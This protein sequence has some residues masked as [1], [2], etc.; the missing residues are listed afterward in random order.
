MEESIEKLQKSPLFKL[1]LSSKEL[2]HSNFWAWFFEQ[3]GN[4]PTEFFSGKIGSDLGKLKNV[5]RETQRK[6]TRK[7]KTVNFDLYLEFEYGSIIIE[8]KI[9]SIPDE[10]QLEEYLEAAIKGNEILFL[11]SPYKPENIDG[12]NHIEYYELL[13]ILNNKIKSNN[14][15]QYHKDLIADY[16][17]FM[18]YLLSLIKG[19]ENM[20][21]FDFHS[22]YNKKNNDYHKFKKIGIHDLFHKYKYNRLAEMLY[23]RVQEK[24]SDNNKLHKHTLFMRGTGVANLEYYFEKDNREQRIELQIQDNNVKLLIGAKNI[25]KH[26]DYLINDNLIQG[27]YSLF[28][29]NIKE[30]TESVIYPKDGGFNKYGDNIIYRRKNINADCKV[31]TIVD[32]FSKFFRDVVDY[33]EKYRKDFNSLFIMVLKDP[34]H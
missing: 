33:T 9:K 29:E 14:I 11:L 1:S 32:Y 25:H 27:L 17:H 12:Y 18:S 31:E 5:D 26:K 19:W 7:N 3:E 34:E 28:Q 30:I 10:T 24:I 6:L 16:Q 4:D 15:S 2:F 23:N 22:E 20:E 8:N 13:N 21:K